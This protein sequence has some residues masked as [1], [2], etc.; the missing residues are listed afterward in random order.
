MKVSKERK[1][2]A[3]TR[4]KMAVLADGKYKPSQKA[5]EEFRRPVYGLKKEEKKNG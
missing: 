5:K 2:R 1:R 3:A 4:A